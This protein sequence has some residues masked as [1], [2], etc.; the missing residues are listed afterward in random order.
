[1]NIY[2]IGQVS[3][4]TLNGIWNLNEMAPMMIYGGAGQ[5]KKNAKYWTRY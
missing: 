2:R 3:G 1:M 4:D 5:L